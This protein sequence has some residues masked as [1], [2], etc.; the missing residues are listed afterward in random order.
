[1]DASQTGRRDHPHKAKE[2]AIAFTIWGKKKQPRLST[3]GGKMSLSSK[4]S[5]GGEEKMKKQYYKSNTFSRTLWKG[6]WKSKKFEKIGVGKSLA[7]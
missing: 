6:G 1:L 5:L 2:K 3:R 4:E 7:S